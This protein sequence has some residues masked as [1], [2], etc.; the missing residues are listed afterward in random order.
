MV[1]ARRGR[2]PERRSDLFFCGGGR[3]FRGK[4]LVPELVKVPGSGATTVD[5]A[6]LW[7]A[8]PRLLLASDNPFSHFFSS[9]FYE[10]HDWPEVGH[11]AS[12][13]WPMPLPHFE[14]SRESK[15]PNEGWSHDRLDHALKVALN[16]LVASFVAPPWQASEGTC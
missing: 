12:S 7:K 3:A 13:P 16:L 10:A 6:A 5:P 4:W 2:R 11:T 9:Y 1:V 15:K 14:V 8:L